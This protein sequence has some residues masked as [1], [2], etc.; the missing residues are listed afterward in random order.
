MDKVAIV[1]KTTLHTPKMVNECI[2]C[3]AE[4]G[5]EGSYFGTC[6]EDAIWNLIGTVDNLNKVVHEYFLGRGFY[7]PQE[8]LDKETMEVLGLKGDPLY[9]DT[10]TNAEY[11]LRKTAI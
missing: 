2:K 11:E 8:I 10:I 5:V 9:D 1:I 6:Y 7:S 4:F 3:F